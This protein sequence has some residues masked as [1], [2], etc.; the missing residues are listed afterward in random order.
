[1][2]HISPHTWI[3]YLSSRSKY[4]VRGATYHSDIPMWISHHLSSVEYLEHIKI[5]PEESVC[6]YQIAWIGIEDVSNPTPF[7]YIDSSTGC[8]FFPSCPCVTTP[9]VHADIWDH[10]ESYAGHMIL[11]CRLKITFKPETK[12]TISKQRVTSSMLPL[13]KEE[14]QLLVF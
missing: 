3:L 14:A 1:M 2:W 8:G 6:R 11:T 10:V 4:V 7:L 5:P 13:L 12:I 9:N